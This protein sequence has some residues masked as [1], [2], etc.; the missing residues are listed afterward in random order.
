[1][2]RNFELLMQV[3]VN[4]ITPLLLLIPLAVVLMSKFNP[5]DQAARTQAQKLLKLLCLFTILSLL[6]WAGLF[7]FGPMANPTLSWATWIWPLMFPL[8]HR[9]AMPT[10]VA[11]NPEMG[12]KLSGVAPNNPVRTAS[13]VSRQH[14]SPLKRWHWVIAIG[15]YLVPLIAIGARGLFP[16]EMPSTGLAQ[17]SPANPLWISW[18]TLLV[19]YAGIGGLTLLMAPR[20]IRMSVVEP[21][22]MVTQGAE[23]LARAYQERREWTIKSLFWLIVVLIPACLGTIYSLMIWLPNQGPLIGVLGGIVGVCGGIVGSAVGT[24]GSIKRYRVQKLKME[25]ESQS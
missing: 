10:L 17:S 3:I 5:P 16:F 15:V 13:L 1:M 4:G 20:M 25:L 19:T 8:M 24:M 21:E 22:P 23:E 14:R 9:L 12:Q 7:F 11:R 6:L 18:I 2:S